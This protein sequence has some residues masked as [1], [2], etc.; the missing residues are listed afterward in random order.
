MIVRTVDGLGGFAVYP[1]VFAML[2][3]L[4]CS[5]YCCNAAGPVNKT[6]GSKEGAAWRE[7]K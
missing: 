6:T 1:A 7:F 2:L 4:Q 5:L 3:I